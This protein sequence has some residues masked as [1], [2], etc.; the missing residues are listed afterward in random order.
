[1]QYCYQCKDSNCEFLYSRSKICWQDTDLETPV[2]KRARKD[3]FE[4]P[5]LSQPRPVRTRWPHAAQWSQ[6]AAE[7]DEDGYIVGAGTS[8]WH[9]EN[10]MAPLWRGGAWRDRAHLPRSGVPVRRRPLDRMHAMEHMFFDRDRYEDLQPQRRGVYAETAHPA[11][12]RAPNM[13][14]KQLVVDDTLLRVPASAS[15]L[16][17]KEPGTSNVVED[18]YSFESHN[19]QSSA[20][21]FAPNAAHIAQTGLSP[22]KGRHSVQYMYEMEEADRIA[23]GPETIPHRV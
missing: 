12:G 4:Y 7:Y 9:E 2:D 21:M 19:P 20:T 13:Y 23:R 15:T 3:A 1:M 8:N 16:H 18:V 11:Y 14:S 5:H 22:T 10:Y 17:V 6:D